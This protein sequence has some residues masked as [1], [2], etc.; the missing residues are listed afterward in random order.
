[1]TNLYQQFIEILTLLYVK[2]EATAITNL[3]FEKIFETTNKNS[4]H[5]VHLQQKHFAQLQ[6]Y[7]FRLSANEPLQHVLE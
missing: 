2:D 7:L 6:N 5:Q 1:M 4:F 3:A